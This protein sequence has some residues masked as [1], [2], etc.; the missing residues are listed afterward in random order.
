MAPSMAEPDNIIW[1]GLSYVLVKYIFRDD[2]SYQNALRAGFLGCAFSLGLIIS[3]LMPTIS[4]FGWYLTALSFFHWSEYY[5]TAVTNPKSLSLE[6]YLLDHSKEY[7]LAAMASWLEFS[8][9]HHNYISRVGL[10]LVII[11]EV[12]RKL[13]MITASTNFNH[14]VQ[15]QKQKDHQLV[16]SGI[17]SLCR[18]PSYVGWFTWSIGTQIIL[19]NPLCLVGYTAVSWKFF[20]Q[21]IYEEEI[22]LLNFFGEDYVEYKKKVGTGLPFIKG[23][24]GTF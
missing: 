16:T 18:H 21:R 13:S 23:F 10:F 3:F 1:C 2:P 15:Y 12:V 14:Y 24:D 4:H 5:T 20:K 19:C 6:S 8:L 17:Y 9:K 22:Y 11:G 7:K